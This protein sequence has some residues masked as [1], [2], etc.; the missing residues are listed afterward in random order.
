VCKCVHVSCLRRGVSTAAGAGLDLWSDCS[1]T[2][3][4]MKVCRQIWGKP[5]K[6]VS[7]EREW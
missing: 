3:Y 2:E 5:K 6:I 1:E 4:V 7:R